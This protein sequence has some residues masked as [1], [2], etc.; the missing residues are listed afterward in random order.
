MQILWCDDERFHLQDDYQNDNID[1]PIFA[2]KRLPQRS[3]FSQPLFIEECRLDQ[4]I[5][6]AQSMQEMLYAV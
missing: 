3:W 2:E 1:R 5:W 6:R 4:F